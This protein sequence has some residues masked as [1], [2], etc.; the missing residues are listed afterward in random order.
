[1][2]NKR[3]DMTMKTTYIHPKTLI[4]ALHPKQFLAQSLE[5][6]PLGKTYTESDVSYSRGQRSGWTDDDD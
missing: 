4:I 6:S 3:N 2:M 1:M 5:G